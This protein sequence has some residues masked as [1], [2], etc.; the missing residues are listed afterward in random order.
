MN[1]ARN[2]KA[3][4]QATI[5]GTA[6]A[7]D[8][9]TASVE[10]TLAGPGAAGPESGNQANIQENR[11]ATRL[12]RAA[13]RTGWSAATLV[14]E[15]LIDRAS[16]VPLYVQIRRR[17]LSMIASWPDPARRFPTDEELCEKFGVARMTVRAAIKEFVD[18][19]LLVRT[20]GLG[21]IV[22][23][24]KVDEHMS[25]AMDFIDQWAHSG[26][27]LSLHIRALGEVGAPEAFAQVMGL[28]PG[29]SV[30]HIERI[31][32]AGAIPVSLDHRYLRLD[33][34]THITK[35]S[36]GA[37]S[38]LD[39]IQE[40]VP[41]SHADMTVEAGSVEDGVADVLDL[42]PGDPMLVRGLVYMDMHDRP[43][44]AG[45]SYYRPDQSGY[46]I[47]LPL[48]SRGA[49]TGARAASALGTSEEFVHWGQMI[50]LA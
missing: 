41:L 34:A 10:S 24:D 13:R 17:L 35:K 33:A 11:S 49:E 32:T 39:L 8:A 29:S 48:S 5:S 26:R 47:R 27:P 44:M 40:A 2:R 46:S 20:R 18:A 30:M 50:R 3:R 12:L 1:A 36:A 22:A 42:M 19:G 25:P 23:I 37:G 21:T 43:V 38:L 15:A 16:P 7:D 6:N 28:P 45:I 31:R 4:G 14:D 9:G